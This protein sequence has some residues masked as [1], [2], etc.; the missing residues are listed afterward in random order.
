MAPPGPLLCVFCATTERS[1]PTARARA[2]RGEITHAQA[3]AQLKVSEATVRR[4]ISK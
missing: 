2:E 3:A 1:R 4:L